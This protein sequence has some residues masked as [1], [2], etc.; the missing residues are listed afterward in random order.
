MTARIM[1]PTPYPEVNAV[2]HELLTG[3]Q[4]I[5]GS[6]FTGSFNATSCAN[7]ELCWQDRPYMPGLTQSNQ[8]IYG[9]VKL[10]TISQPPIR[11]FAPDLGLL[12]PLGG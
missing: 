3:V 5:L 8:T 10:H 9:G 7:R 2:L 11:S 1:H 12:D 6:H 4:A